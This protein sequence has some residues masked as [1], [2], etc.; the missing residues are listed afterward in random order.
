M[1]IP[2][3][4]Q[5]ARAF[6]LAYFFH[7][8]RDAAL[9]VT[10]RALGKLALAERAQLRRG[11]YNPRGRWH[12]RGA[13][14]VRLRTKVTVERAQLLQ[15]LVLLESDAADRRLEAQGGPVPLT[16]EQ[17]VLRFVERLVAVSSRRNSLY[18]AT[19][20][21]RVLH[22]YGTAEVQEL[23][24]TVVQDPDRVPDDSYVRAVKQSLFR[25]L[26][27]RF[28]PRVRTRCGARGEELF[29][30]V[31]PSP[32]LR[33]LVAACLE[34]ITPWDTPC[35]VPAGFDGLGQTLR[36]LRSAGADPDDEHPIEV[37]RMHSLI[38]PPC[39]LALT[40]GL[41]LRPPGEGLA[42]P[43]LFRA[44]E[45]GAQDGPGDR[46][47]PP[48]LFDSDL[49][50]LR[51][52]LARQDQARHGGPFS[53]LVV[54][55]DGHERAR[56]RVASGGFAEL[57]VEEWPELIEVDG[58]DG[59]REVALAVVLPDRRPIAG[60][61]W[62]EDLAANLGGGWGLRIL[63]RTS[64]AEGHP[65]RTAL[66]LRCLRLGLAGRARQA[67]S[68]ATRGLPVWARWA[69]GLVPV[70]TLLA[71]AAL[72]L[73]SRERVLA[74]PEPVPPA[75][76]TVT[77]ETVRG[78][79]DGGEP[80]ALASV[81]SIHVAALSG[82]AAPEAREA[83]LRALEQT[84]H[85]VVAAAP[86]AAEAALKGQASIAEPRPPDTSG[87]SCALELRLV[88]ERGRPLWSASERAND[89]ETG[90]RQVVDDLVR[91]AQEARG[92][93]AAEVR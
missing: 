35:P 21:G 77:G 15:R 7:P 51:S 41:R 26:K 76:T 46:T 11:Y 4:A 52:A 2:N 20:V 18:V 34:R 6:A 19:A 17:L 71:G 44:G 50:T 62:K 3:R 79:G 9:E 37:R 8:R 90:V 30:T 86:E 82:N 16:E 67:W 25:E 49:E 91:R 63:V 64:I 73:D 13:L 85:F 14:P 29:E 83:L 38:H 93:A 61:E 47:R 68:G 23:F 80:I 75:A 1:D 12:Q 5:A 39:L 48:A 59:A 27:Q 65:T 60:E 70:F 78:R 42:L 32:H 81:R 33:T 72:V 57:E 24:S 28:G 10:S 89:C 84:G 54:R 22:G 53:H 45:P 43:R 58:V 36:S 92:A 31:E 66:E 74:P 40:T 69:A 87:P 88:D 55:V 56:L